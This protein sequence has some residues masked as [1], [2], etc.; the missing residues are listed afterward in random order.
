MAFFILA[1]FVGGTAYLLMGRSR[2]I[3]RITIV[4]IVFVAIFAATFAFH[5]PYLT[6]GADEKVWYDETPVKQAIGLGTMIFGMAAKYIFDAIAHRREK[7]QP[8]IKRL[9][10]NLIA[11]I[12][13]SPSS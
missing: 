6:M 10:L 11:G 7:I 12:F 8:A 2:L 4:G 5:Q 13:F 1:I 9:K 3:T